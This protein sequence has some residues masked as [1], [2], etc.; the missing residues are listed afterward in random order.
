MPDGNVNR[1]YY[2]R[3]WAENN[4]IPKHLRGTEPGDLLKLKTGR[5]VN[6]RRVGLTRVLLDIDA[7]DEWVEW[8][9]I[10]KRVDPDD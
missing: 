2:I 4:P 3:K 9:A 1:Y 5:C 10:D 6:V 8:D 7:N